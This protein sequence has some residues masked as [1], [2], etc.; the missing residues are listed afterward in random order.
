[1]TKKQTH[2][3][4]D[5]ARYFELIIYPE[6]HA[7][8]PSKP[9]IDDL[10]AFFKSHYISYIVSPLHDADLLDDFD[11]NGDRKHKKE[12]YHVL[13]YFRGN[14]SRKRLAPVLNVEIS[15]FSNVYDQV[16]AMRY[17]THIDDL[18]FK[19][20]Y[21]DRDLYAISDDLRLKYQTAK[22][23]DYTTEKLDKKDMDAFFWGS[24]VPWLYR[25]QIT[26]LED[27]ITYCIAECDPHVVQYNLSMIRAILQENSSSVSKKIAEEKEAQR[28]RDEHSD[29]RINKEKIRADNEKFRRQETEKTAAKW[30][31]E[32]L[33]ARRQRAIDRGEIIPAGK[34]KS[35]PAPVIGDDDPIDYDH[36]F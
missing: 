3:F 32:A 12:H 4:T 35:A 7:L 26:T 36:P 5:S 27:V 2:G 8:D 31:S 11:E 21:T 22:N 15:Q 19:A 14:R 30:M 20:D 33:E 6:T 9:T 16:K 18:D 13:V 29:H 17:L 24:L 23:A 1:M 25:D 10:I 34:I 28:A